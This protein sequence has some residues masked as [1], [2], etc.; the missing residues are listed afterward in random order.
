MS[1]SY[2]HPGLMGSRTSMATLPSLF[3][4]VP[5]DPSKCISKEIARASRLGPTSRIRHLDTGRGYGTGYGTE[6]NR[7]FA[8]PNA[9]GPG[10]ANGF[11]GAGG[12]FVAGKGTRCFSCYL[13]RDVDRN[14]VIGVPGTWPVQV[15]HGHKR[16][17]RKEVSEGASCP[18]PSPV[19][20]REPRSLPPV[21]D[22]LQR[23]GWVAPPATPPFPVV[24]LIP[25]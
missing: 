11:G 8:T 16:R 4:T 13:R 23:C 19:P 7:Q 5:L 21:E 22:L 1:T 15:L 10:P 2:S 14:A 18:S 6:P 24:L 9:T 3:A 20:S 25:R 12:G 17:G